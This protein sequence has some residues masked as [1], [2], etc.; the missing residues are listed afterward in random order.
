M[1]NSVVKVEASNKRENRRKIAICLVHKREREVK[2]EVSNITQMYSVE[3]KKGVGEKVYLTI[4][5]STY[6]MMF[7]SLRDTNNRSAYKE[8]LLTPLS[9]PLLQINPTHPEK[10]SFGLPLYRGYTVDTQRTH[11]SS[12][13]KDEAHLR[14]VFLFLT[15]MSRRCCS[16]RLW[17]QPVVTDLCFFLPELFYSVSYLCHFPT[18]ILNACHLI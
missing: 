13:L 16:L 17:L 7:N 10:A 5:S 11:R 12:H 9:P 8:A 1:P 3:V 6:S 18:I 2:I 14:P 4:I 15:P